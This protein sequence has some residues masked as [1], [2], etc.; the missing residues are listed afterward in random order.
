MR[1][2]LCALT[3]A[4]LIIFSMLMSLGGCK[5][6]NAA[7]F[8][9]FDGA[10]EPVEL[11]DFI[12]KPI[13]V[14]FWATW[15]GYCKI[16]M[17]DFNDAYH[18]NPDVEFMMINYTDGNDTVDKASAFIRQNGYD[19]PVYYDLTLDASSAYEVEAFPTTLFISRSGDVVKVVSG[20]I[21]AK[22]LGE[23]IALIK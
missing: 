5:Q 18:A 17:P 3:A 20:A 14:N 15:C 8:V 19:F 11:E 21:D 4:L 16:E 23:Y 9:V 22:T 1:R 6:Y 12:G 7:N 2:R 10:M 13:V